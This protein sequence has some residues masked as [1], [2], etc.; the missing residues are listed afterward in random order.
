MNKLPRTTAI[1]F[2]GNNAKLNSYESLVFIVKRDHSLLSC[3]G[4][5]HKYGH[6]EI[7]PLPPLILSCL[8]RRE[9]VIATFYRMW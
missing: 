4:S 5:R 8:P 3:R 1:Y 2:F 9:K 7:S 6:Q